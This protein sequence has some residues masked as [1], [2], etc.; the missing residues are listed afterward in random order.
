MAYLVVANLI[1][2]IAIV[3][4]AAAF[5]ISAYGRRRRKVRNSRLAG[6]PAR[7]Y[8][9]RHDWN[10]GT[11]R[12]NYSSFVYFDVDRDGRY[13]LGD[14][15]MGG[16]VAR[17]SGAGGHILTAR[18][19]VNGFANFTTSAARRRAHVSQA[20][21]YTFAVSVPPGWVCTSGN[22]VQSREFRL[23][24]GAPAGIGTEEMV[25]PVGLAPIR[26]L[27]GRVADAT[28]MIS[29]MRGELVLAT[30]TAGT[31]ADFRISLPDE[32]DVVLVT[33]VGPERRLALSTYPTNVGLLSPARTPL[34]AEARLK[35]IDFDGVN[36]RGLR[37][38]PSGYAGLNWFNLNAMAR[39]FA[40]SS[41]GY[42]NGNTSGDHICY[43]S[44]GHPA[45]FW[46]EKP[47]GFHS[48]MISSAWLRSEGETARI[49]SWSGDRL[50]A[51]DE[52][53]VSALTPLHYAPMLKDITRVRF[54][55]K[56]YWQLA[57]DD[58]VLAR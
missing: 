14:R 7:D 31:G 3:A 36:P 30:E 2:T 27:S 25:K 32:A 52:I 4:A 20:G 13:S 48:A 46:S 50:V 42:V 58:L 53:V 17:L 35:T 10:R 8:A 15:P 1:L 37:K 57:I 44:S 9:P 41:E 29:I 19:N 26:T 12:L 55:S 39:D 33:G 38:I 16:I 28:A 54:S 21:T 34:E 49:E 23:I 6:D 40:G 43:T 11:G 47:F 45:E 18:T 24:E 56:H 51:D 22:A 5:G